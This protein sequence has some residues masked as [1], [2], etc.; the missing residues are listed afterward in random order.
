[1]NMFSLARLPKMALYVLANNGYVE[2]CRF[3]VSIQELEQV[4]YTERRLLEA[5]L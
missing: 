4:T 1:M 2:C 5:M 3:P